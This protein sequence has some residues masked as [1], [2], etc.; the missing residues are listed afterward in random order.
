MDRSIEAAL[1]AQVRE[2]ER[3]EEERAR[4]EAE[5]WATQTATPWVDP[6][7]QSFIEKMLEDAA[8]EQA[9]KEAEALAAFKKRNEEEEA[10]AR[11]AALQFDLNILGIPSSSGPNINLPNIPGTSSINFTLGGGGGGGGYSVPYWG[12]DYSDQ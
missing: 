11:Q 2:R 10:R 1:A 3:E 9:R 4:I 12:Y 7:E 8:K 6:D 5:L